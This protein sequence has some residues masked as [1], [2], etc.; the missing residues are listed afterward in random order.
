MLCRARDEGAALS[1]RLMWMSWRVHQAG[2]LAPPGGKAPSDASAAPEGPTQPTEGPMQP[3]EGDAAP[4]LAEPAHAAKRKAEPAAG[5]APKRAG[6]GPSSAPRSSLMHMWSAAPSRQQTKKQIEPLPS[7]L[8]TDAE[9]MIRAGQEVRGWMAEISRS[10]CR[11]LLFACAAQLA[12]VLS[13][14]AIWP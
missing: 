14:Q 1:D 8:A 3:P 6:V 2:C 5:P 4:S 11:N 9:A 10:Q 12:M 7:S 13:L